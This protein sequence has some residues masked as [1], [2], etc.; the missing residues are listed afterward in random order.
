MAGGAEAGIFILEV[1]VAQRK[2]KEGRIQCY[3][4]SK[5]NRGTDRGR[6]GGGAV[7]L[8]RICQRRP[9]ARQNVDRDG[10]GARGWG[11]R[12]GARSWIC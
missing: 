10:G 7:R 11:E 2:G 5:G 6:A 4:E 3:R 12:H 9:T 8:G 1:A